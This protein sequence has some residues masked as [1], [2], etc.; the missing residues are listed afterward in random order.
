MSDP[1]KTI[2]IATDFSENAR[3]A[4]QW[5]IVIAKEHNSTIVLVHALEYPALGLE[6]VEKSLVTE[7]RAQLKS[8]EQL[9][10]EANLPVRS[11]TDPGKPWEV[12]ARAAHRVKADLI[13]LGTRGRTGYKRMLL[14]SVADR[15]I[16]SSSIPLLVIHP[17][18]SPP[19][20]PLRTILVATDFSEEAALATSAVGTSAPPK[21]ILLHTVELMV[22]WP[23]PDIPTVLPRFWDDAENNAKRQLESVAAGLR[24]DRLQVETRTWRGYAPEIIEQTARE[25]KA[26]LVALGTRGESGLSRLM[27]GSVAASV[28]QHVPCPV[29]IVRKSGEGEPLQ[30]ETQA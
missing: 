22:E 14:G 15:L 5:G 18:D 6:G 17:D 29:L 7:S 10:H 21:L 8:L 4:L 23:T 20:R 28:L 11:E 12:L 3:K 26:D 9:V 27:I 25:I 19:G 24:C 2:L 16:R 30:V 13:I 1:I